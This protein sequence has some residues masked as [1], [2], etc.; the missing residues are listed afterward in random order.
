MPKRGGKS[1]GL[2]GPVPIIH[3]TWVNEKG[4][5]W[6][7]QNLDSKEVRAYI[8]QLEGDF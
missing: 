1:K 8:D 5:L 3:E 2:S 7:S 4:L 6:M